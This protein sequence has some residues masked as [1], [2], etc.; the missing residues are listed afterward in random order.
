MFV[1]DCSNPL[2]L[3]FLVDDSSSIRQDD[4]PLVQTFLQ[5]AAR[6]FTVSREATRIGIIRYASNAEVM[7]RFTSSQNTF[8]IEGAIRNIRHEGGST[9]LA[10]ALVLA[11]RDMFVQQQRVG[12]AK[13]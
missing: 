8:S 7:Y 10:A 6:T 2:D 13:V 5:S 11:Y 9:N 3:V 4:W 12:A 1:T